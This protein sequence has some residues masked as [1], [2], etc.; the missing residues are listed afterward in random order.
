MASTTTVQRFV[1][2]IHMEQAVVR[3]DV[4]AVELRVEPIIVPVGRLSTGLERSPE[5]AANARVGRFSDG[6][7]QLAR[8][9]QGRRVGRFSNGLERW[10]GDPAAARVGSFADGCGR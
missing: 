6:L 2:V 9:S 3:A 1:E 7:E 5:A 4:V 8:G 10:P